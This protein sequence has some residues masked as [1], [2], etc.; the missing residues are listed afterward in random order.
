MDLDSSSDGNNW[1]TNT[2]SS[3]WIKYSHQSWENRLWNCHYGQPTHPTKKTFKP[4]ML[5][6]GEIDISL[7][8]YLSL[9]KILLVP[10]I[11][12][13]EAKQGGVKSHL[14]VSL[15][16]RRLNWVLALCP[17]GNWFSPR[18]HEK[19]INKGDESGRER[20]T[21]NWNPRCAR[22]KKTLIVV[23]GRKKVQSKIETIASNP[24]KNPIQ[25]LQSVQTL[26]KLVFGSRNVKSLEEMEENSGENEAWESL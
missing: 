25:S 4:K 9:R 24:P 16:L 26:L 1:A 17:R 15:R 7:R 10:L 14:S 12:L 2:I 8:N 18:S 22:K 23:C 6:L 3:P 5:E 11:I 21:H 20:S 19:Y 13:H